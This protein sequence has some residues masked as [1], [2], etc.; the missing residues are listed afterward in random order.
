MTEADELAAAVR[1][2]TGADF[3]ELDYTGGYE[4]F[5]GLN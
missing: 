5:T 1:A 4:V 2:G 3:V